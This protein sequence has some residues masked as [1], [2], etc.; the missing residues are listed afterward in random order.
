VAASR[1]E[2]GGQPA[3]AQRSWPEAF[4]ALSAAERLA[5]IGAMVCA[6]SLVLPWYSAPVD[7]LVKTGLGAFGFASAA[8]LIVTGAAL[9]LLLEVGRGRRPPLPLHEGTLLAIA[10]GWAALIVVF[11][12]VD[13]PE[14]RIGGFEDSYDLGYGAFVGLGGAALLIVAGLRVRRVEIARERARRR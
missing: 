7:D 10:G 11:L 1:S 6:G 4:R 12:M 8:L 5:A 3:P 14:L 9:V 13:R 2:S